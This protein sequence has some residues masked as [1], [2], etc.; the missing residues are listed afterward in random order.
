MR[1]PFGHGLSYT[2]FDYRSLTV[3]AGDDGWT[4]RVEVHNTGS[5]RGREVV[6]IYSSLP[7]SVRSRAPRELVGFGHIELDPGQS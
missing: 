5:Y 7:A 1:F 6:Q 3:V 2:T 4:A